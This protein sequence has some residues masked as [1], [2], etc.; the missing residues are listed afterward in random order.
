MTHYMTQVPGVYVPD[1]I[2]KRMDAANEKG[3][4]QG[5]QDEGVKIALEI[6]E[7]I[8]KLHGQG[9]H[10]LHIMPVGWE[11]VVPRIVGEAN[12]LK[13]GSAVPEREAEKVPA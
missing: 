2:I 6:I 3:G 4:P 9:V 13:P 12:L 7:R 11:D 10:G 5:A 1:E 8:K